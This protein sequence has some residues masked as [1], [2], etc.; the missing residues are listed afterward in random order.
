MGRRGLP[1]SGFSPLPGT[2][3]GTLASAHTP[4]PLGE[5]ARAAARRSPPAAPPQTLP[6]PETKQPRAPATYLKEPVTPPVEGGDDGR[7][8]VAAVQALGR[9]EKREFSWK[10]GRKGGRRAAEKE[11]ERATDRASARGLRAGP[12]RVGPGPR[13]GGRPELSGSAS[14]HP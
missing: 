10:E 7:V 4:L 8:D 12:V 13:A 11:R 6:A 9:E 3:H 2:L 14:R 1:P 5:P